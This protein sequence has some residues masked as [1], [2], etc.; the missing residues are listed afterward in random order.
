MAKST[1]HVM[2]AEAAA[3]LGMAQNTIPTGRAREGFPCAGIRLT[4]IRLF[5]RSELER[6]LRQVELNGI[7]KPKRQKR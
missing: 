2:T 3:I 7:R 4:A 1:D 5:K 6:F